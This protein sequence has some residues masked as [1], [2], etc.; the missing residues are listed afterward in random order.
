MRHHHLGLRGLGGAG[1]CLLVVVGVGL[2]I[3]GWMAPTPVQPPAAAARLDSQAPTIASRTRSGS[4]AALKRSPPTSIAIPALSVRSALGPARGV[5]PDGTIDDAPLSGPTWSLPWWYRQGPSPGQPG[6]SVL[7][8]HVDSALGK[9]HLGVF[10]ALGNLSD[11][12]AVD[13]TLADGVVTHWVT[14]SNVLYPD[15]NFP[16]P[17]VYNPSGPPTLRLVTCGGQFDADTGHYQSAD[18]VT[19]EFVGAS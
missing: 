4:N 3:Y 1:G 19:A 15:E 16:D 5:K 13:L 6:S 14:V 11:G 8:G 9:G 10:F 12:Q 18:V 7:L 17:I 2:G